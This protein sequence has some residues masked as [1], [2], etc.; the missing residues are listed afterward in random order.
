MKQYETVKILG[1]IKSK[2]CNYNNFTTIART[3]W[4]MEKGCA[5]PS[6]KEI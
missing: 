4:Y 3:H 1:A 2:N 5:S 6:R